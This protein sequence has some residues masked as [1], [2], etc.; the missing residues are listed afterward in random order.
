MML[1]MINWTNTYWQA[2]QIWTLV[3]ADVQRLGRT[4]NLALESIQPQWDGQRYAPQYATVRAV[5][6]RTIRGS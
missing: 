6:Y 4:V 2:R 5:S 1:S 3:A